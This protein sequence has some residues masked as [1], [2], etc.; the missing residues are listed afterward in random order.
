MELKT[1]VK[2]FYSYE[3]FCAHP[4][5]INLKAKFAQRAKNVKFGYRKLL[6]AK[7]GCSRKVTITIQK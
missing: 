1:H 6:K 7:V 4:L 2:Q 5:E 3:G